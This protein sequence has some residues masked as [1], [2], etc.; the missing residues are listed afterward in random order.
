MSP[1]QIKE[2]LQ[3]TALNMDIAGYDRITGYGFIQADASISTF[4]M[5]A[6]VVTELLTPE[7]IEAGKPLILKGEFFNSSSKNII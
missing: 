5:P 1:Q 4:A 6:P 2:T 3:N 7:G